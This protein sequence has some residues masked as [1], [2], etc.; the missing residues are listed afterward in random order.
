MLGR[1][2]RALVA[3]PWEYTGEGAP[4]EWEFRVSPDEETLALWNPHQGRWT[5]FREVVVLHEVRSPAQMDRHT[6]DWA[7]YTEDLDD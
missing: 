4:N 7:R 6:G 5:V 3:R 2:L 1:I